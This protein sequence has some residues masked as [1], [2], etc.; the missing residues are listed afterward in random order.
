[1][2]AKLRNVFHMSIFSALFCSKSVS[3]WKTFRNFVA[4]KINLGC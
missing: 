4:E 3:F 1:L 2:A